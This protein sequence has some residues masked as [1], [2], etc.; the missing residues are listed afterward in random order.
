MP[1][2]SK[3]SP[4]TGTVDISIDLWSLLSILLLQVYNRT[5]CNGL[6]RRVAASEQRRDMCHAGI[7]TNKPRRSAA[8]VYT[9]QLLSRAP[10]PAA[11]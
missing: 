7:V 5:R 2:P 9:R 8:Y 10:V 1:H 11:A 6:R 4:R 3:Y